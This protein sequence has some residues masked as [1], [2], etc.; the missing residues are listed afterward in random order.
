MDHG[1]GPELVEVSE[2]LLR[3]IPGQDGSGDGSNGRTDDPVGPNAILMQMLVR[4]REISAECVPAA[5][6][7]SSPWTPKHLDPLAMM[8]GKRGR[9]GGRPKS[10]RKRPRRAATPIR[11]ARGCTAQFML[12]RTIYQRAGRRR[13]W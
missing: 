4:T 7:E 3:G 2:A 6:H 10:G 1:L 11:N 5:Q 9:P 12:H 8:A 13:A